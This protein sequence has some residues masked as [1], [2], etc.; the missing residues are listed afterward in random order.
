MSALILD[1]AS[2]T[3]A[4]L[5]RVARSSTPVAIA[6]AAEERMAANRAFIEAVAE[7]GDEVYGL[8]TG[9]GVRKRSRV[10]S[11]DMA[12]FA[13]RLVADHATGQGPLLADDVARASAIVLLN[14]LAAGRSGVRPETV[15]V[16]VERLNAGAIPRIRRYGSTGMGDVTPLADLVSSLLDDV[17]LAAGEALPLIGQGSVTTAEAALATDAAIGFLDDLVVQAALDV[18]AFAAPLSPFDAEGAE[19]RPYAGL[20]RTAAELRA[21]F[22][23]GSLQDETPRQLHGPLAFRNIAHVLGSARDALDFCARQVAI[24]LNAHQQ[25]PLHAMGRDRTVPVANF[26]LLPISQALDLVRIALATCLGAQLERTLKLLQAPLTGLGDGLEPP[27]DEHGH[28]LSEFAWPAQALAAEARLLAQPVSIELGSATQAEGIEDRL[29][30][31]PLG[32]RR[33]DEMRRLGER[34]LAIAALVA[35]Q[36]ID[37]RGA[38][39]LGPGLAPVHARIRTIVPA[40]APGVPVP[41]DL[42]PLVDAVAAGVLTDD[43]R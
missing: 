13:R 12:A 4:D 35:C 9:V 1:G 38:E 33:L 3:L 43:G 6:P 42:E 34:L 2:L 7:R 24:E 37:L 32:A 31:A 40:L 25:N 26:D 29:T 14:T 30:L 21:L 36:G 27:D 11:A 10:S 39:R 18:E 41:Q 20:Q 16:L 17:D 5:V 15:R 23:G 28:G 22:D 8:T 19:V